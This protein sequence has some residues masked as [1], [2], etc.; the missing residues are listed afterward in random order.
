VVAL[1]GEDRFVMLDL[2]EKLRKGAVKLHGEVQTFVFDGATASPAEILD[3]LRS[4]GLMA[5]FKLVVIDNAAKLMSG[6]E[7]EEGAEVQASSPGAGRKRGASKGARELFEGYC[8]SPEPT[9]VLIFRG[10]KWRAPKLEA[11]IKACGGEITS[12]EPMDDGH[13]AGWAIARAKKQYGAVL[14]EDAALAIVAAIGPD[15]AR[16]DMECAK[17]ATAA[18]GLSGAGGEAR[19][20]VEL[21]DELTGRAREEDAWKTQER[22]LVG[23]PELAL[24]AIGEQ[25]EIA[26]DEP[27]MLGIMYLGI[28]RKIDGLCRGIAAGDNPSFVAKRLGIWGAMEGPLTKVARRLTP[29]QS[30]DLLRAAVECDARNKSGRGDPRHN[31]ETLALRFCAAVG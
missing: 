2:T 30:A 25:I 9:A 19:I 23:D 16:I 7:E 31:V 4:V 15:L 18:L 14:N 22:F 24:R 6:G 21:V 17:L 3:E 10:E 12:C 1:L 5:T 11:A 13:A 28:A 29:S 27:V 20:T 26:R 8:Q